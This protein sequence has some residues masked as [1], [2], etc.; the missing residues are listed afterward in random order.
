[1]RDYTF[2]YSSTLKVEAPSFNTEDKISW[3]ITF[4]IMKDNQKDMKVLHFRTGE[5]WGGLLKYTG[6]FP[7]WKI[8]N[9]QVMH[10]WYIENITFHNVSIFSFLGLAHGYRH[11]TKSWNH[12]SKKQ[13]WE[14]FSC[15]PWQILLIYSD[16]CAYLR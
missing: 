5:G 11:N 14:I 9:L 2:D 13:Q 4:L 3:S 1:M 6:N 7:W 10:S 12:T 8:S 15:Y 16:S